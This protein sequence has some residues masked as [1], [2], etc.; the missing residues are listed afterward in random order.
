MIKIEVKKEET[1]FGWRFDVII[2]E[3]GSETLHTVTLH[4]E[5]YRTLGV[6][7]SP[8]ELVEKSIEFLLEREPK[9]SILPAFDIKQISEY[10]PE[11]EK[12][13]VKR[14]A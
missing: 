13:I 4:R 3:N 5:Y 7:K 2:K 12:E 11:Y 6:E 14:S 9:T 1:D 10:F 8:D